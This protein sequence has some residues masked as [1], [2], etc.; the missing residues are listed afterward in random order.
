[1][2]DEVGNN[3]EESIEYERKNTNPKVL[4]GMEADKEDYLK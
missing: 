4:Q 1:M 2:L 3:E